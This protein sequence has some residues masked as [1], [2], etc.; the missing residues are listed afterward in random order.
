MHRAVAAAVTV[1]LAPLDYGFCH[2][3]LHEQITRISERIAAAPGDADLL[4]RRAELHRLH[5]DWS[6]AEKDYARAALLAP[7]SAGVP[8]GR[9]KLHFERRRPRAALGELNQLLSAQPNHVE[10]LVMRARVQRQLGRNKTAAIDFAR[11]TAAAPEP[12][13]EYYLEGAEALAAAGELQRGASV[14]ADGLARLG[15][16]PA[17]VL[18]AI[19][20]DLRLRRFDSALLRID[21]AIQASPRKE[22][23]LER[24]GDVL[25]SAGRPAESA[26]AYRDALAAI[27]ALSP[28]LRNTRS[29]VEL[30]QRLQTKVTPVPTEP[31]AAPRLP[32]AV[33]HEPGAGR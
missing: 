1:L 13:P 4:L 16:V 30:H 28:R 20:L 33:G 15:P 12:Q 32:S 3:D 18:A 29:M 17:L 23:W 8:F 22:L 24:R 9:A 27:A 14:L 21:R 25:K 6:A 10:A 31:G 26:Q 5:R 11:A 7:D 19:E 2:G